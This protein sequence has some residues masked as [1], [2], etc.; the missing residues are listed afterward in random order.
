MGKGYLYPIFFPC[1]LWTKWCHLLLNWYPHFLD[2]ILLQLLTRD[3]I[4]KQQSVYG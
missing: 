3:T 4:I 1:L 2:S